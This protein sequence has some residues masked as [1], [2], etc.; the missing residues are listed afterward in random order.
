M[1]P[2]CHPDFRSGRPG[3]TTLRD[4]AR[5]SSDAPDKQT[6]PPGGPDKQAAFFPLYVANQRRIFAYIFT[7]VPNRADAE[8][9]L[10]ETSIVLWEKFDQFKPGT[11]FFAW[12]CQIAYWKIGNLKKKHGRAKVRFDQDLIDAFGQRSA[13]MSD[14]LDARHEALEHCLKKLNERDRQ[15]VMSRYEPGGSTRQAAELCNRTVQ[16][17]YKAISRIRTALMDCVTRRLAQEVS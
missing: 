17:A 3:V 11:D 12:A 14:E 2:P 13:Q 6:G 4:A 1:R 15:L 7:V 10:Q 16:A 9:I 8:D 5:M